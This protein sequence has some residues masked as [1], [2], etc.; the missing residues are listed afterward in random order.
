MKA[1]Y[2]AVFLIACEG[3]GNS[4]DDQCFESSLEQAGGTQ[5]CFNCVMSSCKSQV[6]EIE[7]A[8]TTYLAC[9]CPGGTFDGSAENACG[10]DIGSDCQAAFVAGAQCQDTT[11]A[12]TCGSAV[13]AG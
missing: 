10:S 7:S 1:F 5:A 12:S 9:V 2:L 11:C 4:T 13:T 8:C 3:S 6:D